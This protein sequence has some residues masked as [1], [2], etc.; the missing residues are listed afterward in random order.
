MVGGSQE[1]ASKTEHLPGSP[2]LITV[3]RF[4]IFVG[5]LP[6]MHTMLVGPITLLLICQ[7][8]SSH[9]PALSWQMLHR[10]ILTTRSAAW[11]PTGCLDSD[12]SLPNKVSRLWEAS[13]RGRESRPYS[14]NVPH[15]TFPRASCDANVHKRRRPWDFYN[16]AAE[17]MPGARLIDT[18]CL[19]ATRFVPRIA[20][21]VDWVFGRR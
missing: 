6:L 18:S 7:P 14:A 2:H 15:S 11:S 17:M 5:H 8:C 3:Y 12:S 10:G 9:L 21:S 13:F 16:F 19:P 4:S 20:S 1:I